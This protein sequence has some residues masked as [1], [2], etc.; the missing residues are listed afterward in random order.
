M[1]NLSKKPPYISF[2]IIILPN[3]PL[4]HHSPFPSSTPN[5]T[6]NA[7]SLPTL[8]GL[9]NSSVTLLSTFPLLSSNLLNAEL[10]FWSILESICL[11]LRGEWISYP[12][13]YNPLVLVR[14]RFGPWNYWTVLG[15][16][17]S[18]MSVMLFFIFGWL[19]YCS[20][21]SINWSQLKFPFF[22]TLF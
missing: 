16:E 12:L 13:E 20:L 17:W 10:M 5:P 18:E 15:Y 9:Y 14:G 11:K 3:P 1:K 21:M 7:P 2:Q 19:F 8:N 22:F 6:L 4:P